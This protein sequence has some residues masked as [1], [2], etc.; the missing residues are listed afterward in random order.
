MTDI[1]Y[2]L[3]L[4]FLPIFIAILFVACVLGTGNWVLERLKTTLTLH[5]EK[6][7][8]EQGLLW[9]S[10]LS[11]LLYFFALGSISWSG[12]SISL[13]GEGLKTF[14]SISAL[15]L[16]ALSLSLPLSVLVSRLHAT[17]QTAR[18]ISIT[19]QK[20]NIDL[21]HSH[22]K[23]LFSY[24]S[25]I[26]EV[27]YLECLNGKFKVH[28]GVHKGYFIGRPEDGTPLINEDLFKDIE[29]ELRSA[30]WQLDAVIR[31][32]NPK[33]TYNFYIAN[34]CSTIYR[35]GSKLGLP[36]INVELAQKSTLVPVMLD[37]ETEEM[38][39]LTVG[40][41]TDEAV[42]AY[43]YAKGFFQNLCDFAGRELQLEESEELK[44]IDV[45]GKFRTIRKEKV[46]ERLHQNEIDLAV[47]AKAKLKEK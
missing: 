15:P 5:E 9:I 20:N 2:L 11:P 1:A 27:E 38:E 46:I 40:K 8:G 31:D 3:A 36:E 43:R 39:L 32:V 44:Y 14:V 34:F 47:D 16:G 4:I 33:M 6:G 22:R 18:Q 45:G 7:L 24:F 41:T 29:D 10:I 19:Q 25:Q 26:G 23:E 17:K 35:L 13:T 42:A 30:R 28:P 12:H 37:G 21:F